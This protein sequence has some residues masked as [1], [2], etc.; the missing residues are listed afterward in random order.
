MS[1]TT[2]INIAD[3]AARSAPFHPEGG[4][5]DSGT[6]ARKQKEPAVEDRLANLNKQLPFS[7]EAEKGVLSC[8]FQDTTH[9]AECRSG[10]P[11]AA[12]YHLPSSTIYGALLDM[13]QAGLPIDVV[14]VSNWLRNKGLLERVGG[15]SACSELYTFVPIAA[16]FAYY[17]KV[18]LAKYHLRLY[19]AANVENIQVAQEHGKENP[20]APVTD[21]I[22]AGEQRVFDVLN[23]AQETGGQGQVWDSAEMSRQWVTVMEQIYRNRGRLRGMATGWFDVDRA[24]GGLSPDE[25]GDLLIIAGYPGNGKSTAGA[26]ILE[27]IAAPLPDPDEPDAPC[28][29][30]PT[31]VFPLEMGRIGIAHRF[32][33]GRAGVN[34][35]ASRSGYLA[36]EDWGPIG[37]AVSEIEKKQIFWD[38]SN[39]ITCA[40]LHARVKVLVRKHGVRCVIIDHFTHI[41]PTSKAGLSDE[42]LGQKEVME[43]LH[44]MRRELGIL[45]IL[46]VQL[47][48]SGRDAPAN[49]VPNLGALRG[50]SEIGELATQVLFLHRPCLTVPFRTLSGQKVKNA[51]RQKEWADKVDYY[52]GKFPEAW[53]PLVTP[54]GW[55]ERE[56]AG[57]D[58]EGEPL[59]VPKPWHFKDYEEHLVV[60]IAKN[61]HGATP[62]NICLRFNLEH[63]RFLNRTTKLYSGNADNRQV[64]LAGF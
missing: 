52:R 21:V 31:A 12:F 16:H 57:D 9:I 64:E 22:S 39:S 14:T 27:N 38:W 25:D 48:K 40:D 53:A 61:R 44:A 60:N 32:Y 20:D 18:M 10:L 62:D 6:P 29:G 7:D 3:A 63:Q 28:A 37:R 17:R 33:L 54:K 19:I 46:L 8:L 47:N 49:A 45:I 42:R 34:I 13:D 24:F 2:T 11:L 30:V 58:E 35:N 15:S 41:K 26:T 1:E 4:P 50:A 56:P 59:F 36:K 55:E 5:P 43:T 23:I 51:A